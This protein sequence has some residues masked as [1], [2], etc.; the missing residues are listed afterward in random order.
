MCLDVSG[1]KLNENMKM[2]RTRI[3]SGPSGRRWIFSAS[4]A[5][6]EFVYRGGSRKILCITIEQDKSFILTVAKTE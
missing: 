6:T 2:D 3:I 4:G 1:S 5:D